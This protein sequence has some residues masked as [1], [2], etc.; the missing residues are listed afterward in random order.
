MSWAIGYDTNWHRDIGYGVPSTCDLPGCNEE[1]DRGLSY[2]CGDEPYGGEYGCGLYFCPKHFKYRKPHGA[3]RN[4][5]L[6]PKCYN[7]KPPFKAKPDT[8]EWS[9]WKLTDESWEVWRQEHP[10]EVSKIKS[11]LN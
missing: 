2:V 4:I 1:I 9:R 10:E 5:Q 3:D 7:Y 11:R 6:C 8:E